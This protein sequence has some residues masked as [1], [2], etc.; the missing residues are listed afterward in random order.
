MIRFA[1]IFILLSN[2]LFAQTITEQI[3]SEGKS[4]DVGKSLLRWQPL[5]DAADNSPVKVTHNIKYGDHAKQGFD[6]YEPVTLPNAPSPII[7]FLHG[8][9][10]VAGDKAMYANVGYHFAKKG[11]TTVVMTYRLAPEYKWPTGT[12]DLSL[13]LKWIRDH[14]DQINADTSNIYLFGHSA[15]AQHVA[16]YIFEEEYQI[17]ND[18]V[19]GAILASG[20]VY[21]TGILNGDADPQYYD[22]FGNDPSKYAERLVL[23][24]LDGRKMPVFVSYA[25]YDKDN[26]QY[27]ASKIITALFNRDDEMPTVKQLMDHNHLSEVFHFNT[28]DDD[29]SDD[30]IKF[31]NKNK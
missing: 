2:A 17:E 4:I 29:F 11:I 9:S 10:F 26:F 22:Y 8:G 18:G 23:D 24:D 20:S 6:L 5:W 30:I 12:I 1:A 25:E 27:Q 19:S 31:I 21:D 14:K 15:G 7:I 13:Q 16:S 28:G 3:R